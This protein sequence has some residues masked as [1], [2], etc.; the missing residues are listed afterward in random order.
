VVVV[1]PTVTVWVTVVVGPGTV[2][3]GP[4]AVTV[5][6]EVIVGPVTVVAAPVTVRV[7]PFTLTLRVTVRGPTA[8]TLTVPILTLCPLCRRTILSPPAAVA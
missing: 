2:T 8:S 1:V 3:V 5:R 7:C 6:V 4:A